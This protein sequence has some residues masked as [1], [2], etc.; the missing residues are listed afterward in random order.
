MVKMQRVWKPSAL[1]A[2]AAA[3]QRE[4]DEYL[5]SNAEAGSETE[6]ATRR[7]VQRWRG[8]WE[9]QLPLAAPFN[10]PSLSLFSIHFSPTH[11]AG[12]AKPFA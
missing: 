8:R 5:A 9:S 1:D 10:D 2:V 6:R 12:E 7:G 4:F 11:C 3:H